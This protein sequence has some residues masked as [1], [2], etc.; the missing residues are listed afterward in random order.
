MEKVKCNIDIR[1]GISFNEVVSL[2]ESNANANSFFTVEKTDSYAVGHFLDLPENWKDHLLRLSLFNE[3]SE[4]RIERD[5]DSFSVRVFREGEN[6]GA[7]Q[8]LL[9]KE[10]S[11]LLS[12]NKACSELS[13]EGLTK[14]GYAEYFIEDE[15]SGIPL[16][17]DERLTGFI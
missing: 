16:K 12:K 6:C 4:V 7:T 9:K 10:Q 3:K 11:Y 17:F 5:L 14:L 8:E 13:K 15:N 1:Y 2:I